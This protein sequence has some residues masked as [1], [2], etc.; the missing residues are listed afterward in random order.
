VKRA[1]SE[2]VGQSS[3]ADSAWLSISLQRDGAEPLHRQLYRALRERIRSGAARAGSALPSSRFFASELGVARSTVLAAYEQLQAEGYVEGRLGAGVFVVEAPEVVQGADPAPT[4]SAPEVPIGLKP[5]RPGAPDMR[6]FPH[7]R[8]TRMASAALRRAG[9][10]LM[11]GADPFGL[12]AL[13]QALAAHLFEWRGLSIPPENLII[14]AGAAGALDLVFD[15][16]TQPGDLVA[17]ENPG[18]PVVREIAALRALD[19]AAIDIDD[20]GFVVRPL[21]ALMRAPKVTVVTPSNQFPLGMAATAPRRAELLA[22]AAACGCAIV[23]DDYDSEFRYAGPPLPAL[24][25]EPGAA[26]VIYVGTFSKVFSPG[27]RIGY[28]ATPPALRKRFATALQR[29]GARASLVPQAPL[30]EFIASGEFARHLRRMRRLY[31]QRRAQLRAILDHVFGPGVLVPSP[32]DAGMHLTVAFGGPL[33]RMSDLEAFE[34]A[35]R[36]GVVVEP[37][38][39]YAFVPPFRQGLML[40]FAAFTEAEMRDAAVSLGEALLG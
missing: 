32:R 22:W 30:A 28:L 16:L 15:A 4:P 29:L 21:R 8:W 33:T 1:N 31:A 18:Y 19:V 3:S 40:G 13:R 26:Q 24:A 34:R 27:L 38:S 39:R 11:T 2:K 10:G 6:Q 20:R 9:P 25:A 17:V 35:T 37:L 14:T 36:A 12:P 7:D 23:E 5:F